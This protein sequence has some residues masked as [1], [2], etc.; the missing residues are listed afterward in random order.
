MTLAIVLAPVVGESQALLGAIAARLLGEHLGGDEDAA[1]A[2]FDADDILQALED[3]RLGDETRRLVK[4]EQ[5]DAHD[6]PLAHALSVVGDPASP[7]PTL[8]FLGAKVRQAFE[9]LGV[10][11]RADDP[12]GRDGADARPSHGGNELALSRPIIRRTRPLLRFWRKLW[13]QVERWLIH[14]TR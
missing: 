14:L 13:L 9:E 3:R 11:R 6:T 8:A 10:L 7:P 12:E 5:L 1:R 2:I 4:S